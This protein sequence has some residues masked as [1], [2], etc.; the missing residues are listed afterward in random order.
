MRGRTLNLLVN[1]TV[2]K[3]IIC[4]ERF[5]IN[6]FTKSTRLVP[7]KSAKQFWKKLPVVKYVVRA[8][9]SGL[10]VGAIQAIILESVTS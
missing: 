7:R 1:Y 6:G 9:A 8:D 3:I 10:S 4:P 2:G 5:F